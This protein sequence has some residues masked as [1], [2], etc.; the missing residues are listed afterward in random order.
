MDRILQ[1]NLIPIV[2]LVIGIIVILSEFISVTSNRRVTLKQRTKKNNSLFLGYIFTSLSKKLKKFEWYNSVL[3]YG[4]FIYDY[5]S[6]DSEEKN[7]KKAEQ[8]ITKAI[9]INLAILISICFLNVTWVIKPI[10]I[11][12]INLVEYLFIRRTIAIKRYK[13]KREFPNFVR[14]F[15]EGYEFS[16]NVKSA[17][18]YTIKDITPV[19]QVHV[20][21]LI[22][23]LSSTTASEEAFLQ[24]NG[25]ISYSMCSCFISTVQSAFYTNKNTS[26]NFLRLQAI[27]NSDVAR[28]KDNTNKL[29]SS[30]N[31]IYLWIVANIITFFVVGKI[32]KTSTG[33]YFLTT[34]TGQVLLLITVISI[35]SAI[36]CIII[37]DSV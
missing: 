10:A 16:K 29:S 32:A 34:E 7:R 22:N 25:R 33:N 23:Q 11:V 18:E 27:L 30:G 17:F 6:P 1:L 21:R 12:I 19:F 4:Q 26:D 8:F 20:N 28:E 36:A 37:S 5:F 9:L 3:D 2:I 14:S 15:I 35:I 31:T 13:L 24:F